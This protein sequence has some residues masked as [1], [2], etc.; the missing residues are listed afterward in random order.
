MTATPGPPDATPPPAR[1]A[2]VLFLRGPA[3]DRGADPVRI[4]EGRLEEIVRTIQ[5]FAALRFD[6]RAPIGPDGDLVDA[7]GAGVNFLGEELAASFSEIERRV[8][9]R[10]A[11][12]RVATEEL[13]HRALYD[14]LTDLPN[15]AL[16]WEFMSRRLALAG[17][18]QA[19]FAILFVDIDRFKAVNDTLGHAAGDRLL[20]NVASRLRGVVRGSDI[21]ARL[22][23][24]EFV[25]LADD[26]A[27]EKSAVMVAER[28]IEVLQAPYE[29]KEGRCTVTVSVGVAIGPAGFQSADDVV[30]AA[31]RAM[32]DAKGLGGGR[33]LLYREGLRRRRSG[34]PPGARRDGPGIPA[35]SGQ[36]PPSRS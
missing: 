34:R 6:A 23:G 14:A 36:E 16:F 2:P 19:G 22:G 3:P 9:E 31:D 28:V 30:A 18:S 15:R 25:I 20:I 33:Y 12:L 21:A 24:D 5:E 8:A 35:G 26:V 11:E 7:I 27:K 17:R 32:Y 13:T 4:F 29:F 10:T 1:D